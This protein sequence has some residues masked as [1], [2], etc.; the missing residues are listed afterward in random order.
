MRRSLALCLVVLAFASTNAFAIGEARITGKVLDSVTKQPIP[1]AVVTAEATE[2]R[3]FKQDYKAKKDGSYAVFLID[4]TVRYKFT[5]SAPGYTPYS[6]T[7]K[8]TLGAPNLKD[9]FLAKGDAAATTAVAKGT[10][11][12]DPAV[13]AYNAGAG[14]ANEGKAAEAIAKFN[15]AVAAKPDLT[16]AW[17]ALAKMQLREKNYPKAI[18]AANKV[19]AVDDEDTDM[20]TVLYNAYTATGDKAKAAEAKKKMP[21]NAA[22]LFNDAA[23]AINGG[24]DADAEPLLKQAIAIDANFAQ[25]YYELGMLY[26]RT[27]NNAGAREN[28]TKYLELQPNGKDAPTAKEMLQYVK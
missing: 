9:V 4:G 24:Q 16:A 19:L 22:A 7:I 13:E 8:L 27:Q 18:E 11:K 2:S 14:L 25:A 3:T 5:W 28:L 17:I 1:D 23:K 21:A 12:A 15:E 6:E 26:V 10:A 20:Y